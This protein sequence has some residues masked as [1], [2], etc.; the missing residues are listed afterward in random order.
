MPCHSKLFKTHTEFGVFP[1]GKTGVEEP[2]I[3]QE[4]TAQGSVRRAEIVLGIVIDEGRRFLRKRE[5]GDVDHR[6]SN[7]ST[8]MAAVGLLVVLEKIWHGKY[9]V[10]DEKNVSASGF[11]DG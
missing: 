7:E 9:I 6:T 3:E 4:R 8:E 2:C 11:A 1:A 10:V 5:C